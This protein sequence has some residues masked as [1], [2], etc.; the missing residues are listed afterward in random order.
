MTDAAFMTWIKICGITNL[1]DARTAVEAGADALGFVFADQ[2]PRRV[3]ARTARDIVAHLP[4]NLEKVGVF[5][6]PS[7]E[8]V[9]AVAREARLT[10]VQIHSTVVT[11]RIFEDLENVEDRFGVAKLI[12][13]IP[14]NVLAQSGLVLSER[15]KQT[16]HAIMVDSGSWGT[17][18]TGKT[19]DWKE[20]QAM[21]RHISLTLPVIIAGGLNPEN[22]GEAIEI[23]RPY[24]VDVS[25]GVEARPG[26]KD[27]N[28]IR[29]FVQAV[30]KLRET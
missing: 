7:P 23:F 26:K 3:D 21:V 16:I 20:A 13:V 28:K 10:A 29:A 19:F 12:A 14:G 27:P 4:G 2:S 5:V 22:V 18:G 24:G 11:S 8:A 9:R 1:E 25:S 17:G 15:A 30:R 6:G